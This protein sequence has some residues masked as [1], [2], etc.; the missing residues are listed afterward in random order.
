[1]QT[2]VRDIRH[3]WR[4]LQKNPSFTAIADS[5]IGV[6]H[7]RQRRE[8][9]RCPRSSSAASA[10]SAIRRAWCECMTPI[11]LATRTCRPFRRRI[12][13]T[14][15]ASRDAFEDLGGYWYSPGSGGLLVERRGEPAYLETV[16]AGNGFFSTLGVKPVL[17]RPF[18]AEENVVGKDAVA[19]LSYRLWQK[20]ISR[21]S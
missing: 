3:A 15:R 4:V 9:C 17:G 13:M 8:L 16:F 2:L 1:M 18:L 6:R 11:P 12:S 5:H 14:S 20:T 21:G 7:R 19:I 10:L